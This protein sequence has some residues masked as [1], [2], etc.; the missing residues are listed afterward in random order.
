MNRLFVWIIF[1]VVLAMG[2]I[3]VMLG[4]TVA[5]DNAAGLAHGAVSGMRAGGDGAGR[6]AE[7]GAPAFA[8][9]CLLLLFTVLLCVLGV[10]P[11]RRTP[12]FL[13]W[14]IL[15]Y[16]VNLFVWRQMWIGHQAFLATGGTGWF[17]G[18]P[19]ATAW[20]VYGVWFAGV[21]LVAIYSAG[22]RHYILSEDDE[23]RFERL[24]R[25]MKKDAAPQTPAA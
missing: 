16:A 12:V 2:A 10:S 23:R 8:F 25:E 9:N 5:P 17:L 18:F 15:V 19:A 22:F 13:G 24:V 14:M 1:A 11:A 20:Q 3:L 4:F 21:V 7:I 6:L